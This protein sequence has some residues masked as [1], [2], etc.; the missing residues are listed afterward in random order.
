MSD[1]P[2]YGVTR[3][4]RLAGLPA[5]YAGRTAVGTG[6]RLGGRPAE[7]V[8]QEIQQRTA[9]QV[10]RVLGDLKGGAMKLGQALSVFE[11]AL[12]AEIAGP[13]RATLPGRPGPRAQLGQNR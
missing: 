7:L 9:V 1:L 8:N 12:P 11:A 4:A 6:R 10:F 13:Y 3:T 2:R 5:G